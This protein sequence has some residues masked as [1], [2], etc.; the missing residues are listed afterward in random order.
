MDAKNYDFTE[1]WFHPELPQWHRLIEEFASKPVNG[2]EIG[3]FEGRSAVWL[4]ENVCTHPQSHLTAIDTFE[5]SPEFLNGVE[6]GIETDKMESRFRHNISVTGK[7]DQVKIIKGKSFDALIALNYE[8]RG[9]AEQRFDFAYVDGSHEADDVL[10]DITLL[11][12][13]MKYN[14][15]VIFDDYAM[16]R[17][18]EPY[19]NPYVAIDG[20]IA[21]NESQIEI[22]EKNYQLAIRKIKGERTFRI[23]DFAE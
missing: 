16:R 10:C 22:L 17:Y 21:A 5:G 9:S 8:N 13:L 19:N 2:I 11:W 7:M 23:I 1:N 4:L 20:F 6:V 14:G 15:I 3:C 18:A 12:P